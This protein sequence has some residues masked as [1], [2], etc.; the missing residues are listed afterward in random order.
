MEEKKIQLSEESAKAQLQIFLD[1]YELD[2]EDEDK[3]M[4]R[5]MDM[6]SGKLIRAIMKG[7]LEFSLNESDRLVITQILK[8]SK[9]KFTYKVI[10]GESK[11]AM[12]KYDVNDADGKMFA[13]MGYLSGEGYDIMKK[14]ESVD[15]STMQAI[16]I[17]LMRV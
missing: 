17:F 3:D 4:K 5:S 12:R 13:L 15:L 16:A 2:L 8:D 1:Y 11:L 9:E 7:R 14:L 10:D 6:F